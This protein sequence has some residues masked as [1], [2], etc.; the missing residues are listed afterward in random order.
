ML[1]KVKG[2]VEDPFQLTGMNKMNISG[3]RLDGVLGYTVLARFRIQYDF[4]QPHLVW[5]KLDWKPPPPVC[6]PPRDRTPWLT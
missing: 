3:H 2:R 6:G 4:T 5:T 1:R